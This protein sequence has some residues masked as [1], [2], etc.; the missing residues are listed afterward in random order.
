MSEPE[1]PKDWWS[2]RDVAQYLGITPGAV[3]TY[4]SRG[5]MPPHERQIGLT[6]VWKPATIRKWNKRRPRKGQSQQ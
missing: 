3:R 2:V 4:V 6:N 1:L 5:D